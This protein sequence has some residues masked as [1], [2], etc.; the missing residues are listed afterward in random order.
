M[1]GDDA[2][3]RADLRAQARQVL[4]TALL[5]A[6]VAAL[7]RFAKLGA[8][9]FWSDEAATLRDAQNL[10]GVRGYPIGYALIGGFVRLFGDSEFA[11]RFIPALVGSLTPAA[12]YLTGRRLFSERA[13]IIAGALLALS[14]YHLFFSQFARYYTLVML[15]GVGAMWCGY[16]AIEHNRRRDAALSVAL[17]ALAVLTHWSA[18]MLAPALAIYALVRLR[19]GYDW[20]RNGWTLAILFGPMLLGLLAAF[21]QLLHFALSWRAHEGFSPAR[22]ALFWIKMADRVEVPVL[23][24]AVAGGWMLWR[25]RDPRLAWLAAFAGVPLFLTA[26]FVGFAEGGSRFGLVALPPFLLLAGYLADQFIDLSRD[27]ARTVAWMLLAL[28]LVSAGL[29]DAFY[30]TAEQGERPRWRDA[31][32]YVLSKGEP[33]ARVA[34]AAPEVYDYCARRLGF[35]GR[36]AEPLV[37]PPCEG[38]YDPSQSSDAASRGAEERATFYIITEQVSNMAP[39]AEQQRWLDEHATLEKSFPLTVRLLDY[40]VLVYRVDTVRGTSTTK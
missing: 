13:G 10:A 36:K 15:L 11:A 17:L 18:L 5:L 16:L 12:I 2:I 14:S 8:W 22:F 32:E 39:T 38:S 35:P 31:T 3:A 33:G 25:L 1:S 20:R 19:E 28:V 24:C 27:R 9:S 40:S 6:V 7:L 26:L 37:I 30:F 23:L 34:A 21:P 29:R 4:M